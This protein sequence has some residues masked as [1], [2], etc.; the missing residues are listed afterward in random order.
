MSRMMKEGKSMATKPGSPNHENT[1]EDSLTA[2]PAPQPIEDLILKDKEIKRLMRSFSKE[3]IR[4]VRKRMGKM[5]NQHVLRFTGIMATFLND[6][7]T[8][9]QN[10]FDATK[11]PKRPDGQKSVKIN[12]ENFKI[13]ITKK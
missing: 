3:D 2:P 7:S 6:N 13:S 5:A 1:E 12:T 8:L 11:T 10:V 4:K 9:L